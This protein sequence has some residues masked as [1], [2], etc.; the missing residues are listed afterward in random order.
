MIYICFL[1]YLWRIPTRHSLKVIFT[2]W[3]V[4]FAQSPSSK[5]RIWNEGRINSM[6]VWYAYWIRPYLAIEISII[7]LQISREAK[8]LIL[9]RLKVPLS[10]MFGAVK[11][12]TWFI[13]CSSWIVKPIF[14]KFS[15]KN[16]HPQFVWI[17]KKYPS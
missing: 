16:F 9:S 5:Q 12:G 4:E 7:S 15:S 14:K 8:C 3:D 2:V 13:I 6:I 17:L 1:I 11:S 10:V